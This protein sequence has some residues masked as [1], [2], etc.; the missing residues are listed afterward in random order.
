[1]HEYLSM[2]ISQVKEARDGAVTN[3]R[4][5]KLPVQVRLM[6]L[7]L[8]LPAQRQAVPYQGITTSRLS[9]ATCRTSKSRC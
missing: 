7:P 8:S 6:P 1:M 3:G 2:H 9:N 5:H 4:I